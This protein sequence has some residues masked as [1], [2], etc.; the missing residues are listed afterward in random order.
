VVKRHIIFFFFAVLGFELRAYTLSRSTALFVLGILEIGSYK[1]FAWA[2]FEP[3]SSWSLLPE[4]LG[5]QVWTF[6]S[7]IVFYH[8][9]FNFLQSLQ[10]LAYIYPMIC[11]C[12]TH[13]PRIVFVFVKLLPKRIYDKYC[14]WPTKSKILTVWI[15]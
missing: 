1:L 9:S 2:G 13:K 3:R 12:M 5:L 15:L 14:V 8:F 10:T 6:H 11:F 4:K 7:K